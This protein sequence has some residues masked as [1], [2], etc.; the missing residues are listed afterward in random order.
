VIGTL[1]NLLVGCRHRKMTRPITLIHKVG[2]RVAITYVACLDC[3]RRFHYDLATMRIG[4][5]V[6]KPENVSTSL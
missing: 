6:S 2:E 3:G 5:P 1:V 4:K